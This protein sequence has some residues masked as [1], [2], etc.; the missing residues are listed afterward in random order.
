MLGYLGLASPVLRREANSTPTGASLRR[1]LFLPFYWGCLWEGRL[2]AGHAGTSRSPA[3]PLASAGW[4]ADDKRPSK[5]A[6][7]SK[8]EARFG[9]EAKHSNHAQGC[10]CRWCEEQA[11]SL[12]LAELGRGLGW[13]A[14]GTPAD[15][16][17]RHACRIWVRPKGVGKAPARQEPS[18]V[19]LGPRREQQAAS[20]KRSPI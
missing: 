17:I 14:D 6:I 13:P 4:Y 7:R 16:Q 8:S 5:P 19:R 15:V 20:G 10:S 1:S 3:L 9:I 18:C 11:A 2:P 12:A